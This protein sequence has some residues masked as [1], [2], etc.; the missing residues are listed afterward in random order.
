M[1]AV[2]LLAT[3]ATWPVAPLRPGLLVVA[4]PTAFL[5]DEGCTPA[6]A[7]PR[8]PWWSLS[9]RLLGVA[10][11]ASVL[12]VLAVA[13]PPAAAGAVPSGWWLPPSAVMLVVL[14]AASV[15]RWRGVAAP[16]DLVA[17]G[18][19]LVVAALVLV[20]PR[21][22][23]AAAATVAPV[24]GAAEVVWCGLALCAVVVLLGSTA[25]LGRGSA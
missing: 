17:G 16:G 21:W 5:L 25:S 13:W 11:V 20:G 19:A 14:A 18:A 10:P 4:L 9:T 7:S 22:D 1:V 24:V 23:W 2:G 6:A 12:L 3:A 8:S 15:A